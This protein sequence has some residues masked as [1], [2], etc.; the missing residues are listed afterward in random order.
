[1]DSPQN[2]GTG[3]PDNAVV[4]PAVAVKKRAQIAN[5]T[6][7]MFIWIIVA[8]V[9]LGFGLVGSVFLIQRLVY[10]QKVLNAQGV[11]LSNISYDAK[12]VSDLEANLRALDAD[13]NLSLVKASPDDQPV[14]AI[15][16][17]LPSDPNT[18]A[19]GASLQQKLLAPVPGLNVQSLQVDQSAETAGNGTLPF[20]LTVDG[21]QDSIM[22]VLTNFER[23]IR[24]INVTTLDIIGGDSQT[25][26]LSGQAYYQ[27]SLTF[28]LKKETIKP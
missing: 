12:N 26:T 14:Q 8:S 3:M 1:M 11:A 7:T 4:A 20:T 27:P 24:T 23:S 16:D 25:M 28:D 5:A 18:L 22:N 2:T 10:N 15:L 21:S 13:E 19:L 9:V 6:R 17:A